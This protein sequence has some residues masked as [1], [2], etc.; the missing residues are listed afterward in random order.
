MNEEKIRA[1]FVFEI[2]GRPPEYIKESLNQFID[3][4]GENPTIKIE[5]RKVHEPK[6]IEKEN[7]SELYSTFA[8]VELVGDNLEIIIDIVLNMLPAHVEIIEPSD[9]RMQNFELSSVL[10]KLT[11]KIH[12]YDEIAKASLIE[13]S[14]LTKRLEE[15]QAKINELEKGKNK[16]KTAKEKTEKKDSKKKADKKGK[17]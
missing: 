11:V 7:V 2:M 9:I 10:S 17:K 8:E 6:K 13:R 3:K 15:M 12:K 14:I 5:E 4:L 1:M 16:K